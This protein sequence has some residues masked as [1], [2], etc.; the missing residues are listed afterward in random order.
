[1]G[2][3]GACLCVRRAGAAATQLHRDGHARGLSVCRRRVRHHRPPR[4][5]PCSTRAR[6]RACTHAS[7]T[8]TLTHAYTC[9]CT[10]ACVHEHTACHTHT[11]TRTHAHAP[12]LQ[13]CRSD[14]VY[15]CA[16]L[17]VRDAC[18]CLLDLRPS[19]PLAPR[20]LSRANP[21]AHAP[22][23]ARRTRRPSSSDRH[24]RHRRS[25]GR[26]R[27]C[28]LDLRPAPPLAPRPL[29]RTTPCSAAAPPLGRTPAPGPSRPVIRTVPI[30]LPLAPR[31]P[32]PQL[33]RTG[34]RPIF[35]V[36][37]DCS[38]RA[39]AKGR[40]QMGVIIMGP[41]TSGASTLPND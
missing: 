31:R 16:C 41:P 13:Y 6:A 9:A 32:E 7:H 28:L 8:H 15:A 25:A 3:Q 35:R 29:S 38:P 17:R 39:F 14:V 24:R 23:H 11:R 22:T 1:M 37:V 20:P 18:Q 5:G 27:K 10:H 36:V 19:P 12:H 26:R 33:G 2:R 21:H 34:P 30:R 4:D 40:H